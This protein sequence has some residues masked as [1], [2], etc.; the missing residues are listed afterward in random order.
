MYENVRWAWGWKINAN[1]ERG[2]PVD[3]ILEHCDWSMKSQMLGL[4]QKSLP[5][6]GSSLQ[7]NSGGVVTPPE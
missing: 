4:P 2:V 7:I 1:G 6:W 3:L 5:G